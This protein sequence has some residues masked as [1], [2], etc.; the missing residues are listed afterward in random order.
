MRRM[1]LGVNVSW[2]PSPMYVRKVRLPRA[3]WVK[4]WRYSNSLS[5]GGR[6]SGRLRRIVAGIA[7]STSASS[8]AAPTVRSIASRSSG[9]GPMWRRANESVGSSVGILFREHLVL[10]AVEQRAGITGIGQTHLHHP[11]GMRLLVD[12]LRV[13]LEVRVHLE[14]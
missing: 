7:S 3:T 9:D 6:L 5:A 14:H 11:G 8:D 1:T 12:R 10:S 4:R 2:Y 13:I